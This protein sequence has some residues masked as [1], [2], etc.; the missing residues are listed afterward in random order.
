MEIEQEGNKATEDKV[1][2]VVLRPIPKEEYGYIKLR[3]RHNLL[4]SLYRHRDVYH[5]LRQRIV[6]TGVVCMHGAESQIHNR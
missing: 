6:R 3:P 5:Y 2:S 1:R 4:I